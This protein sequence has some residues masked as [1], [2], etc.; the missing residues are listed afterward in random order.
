VRFAVCFSRDE[1]NLLS[2]RLTNF[3]PN[4]YTFTKH[5]AEQVCVDFKSD[6][7]LPI[8]IFRPSIVTTSEVE[9]IPGWC[10][11]LNG[12][13]AILIGVATGVIHVAKVKEHNHLDVI[14]I[15]VCVKGMLIAAW[16]LWKDDQVDV[17]ESV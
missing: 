17:K 2:T 9:P 6:H 4:T 5:M 16:K 12:P 11:N 3:A 15:D 10:D 13:M 1:I 14:P 7:K 8:V